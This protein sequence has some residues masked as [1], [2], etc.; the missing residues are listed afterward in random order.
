MDKLRFIKFV[1]QPSPTMV[2]TILI[3]D[4]DPDDLEF[5]RD[6]ASE[7]D[8]SIKC[9]SASNGEN[10]LKMLKNPLSPVPDFIFLDINMPGM[11]GKKCLYE[12]KKMQNLNDTP[13]II[14]TTSKLI[15]DIKDIENFG[16]VYFVTKP[17]RLADLRNVIS[18][19][20]E[21]K[22]EKIAR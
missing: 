20:I 17:T 4:D 8:K 11:S 16:D 3:I 1:I 10:A 9:M 18:N 2:K 13:V 15:D 7:I 19:V 6:A 21:M 22:W 5:F 12:I 14:Y